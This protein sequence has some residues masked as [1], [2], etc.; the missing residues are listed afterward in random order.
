MKASLLTAFGPPEVLQLREDD[1]PVVKANDVL[2]RVHATT[3]N[4][5][6][7]LVRDFAAVSPST[8]HMPWLFWCLS[9]LAFGFGTPRIR[10]LELEDAAAAHRYAM[11]PDRRG[12]VVL[13][14]TAPER[15][16]P[17]ARLSDPAV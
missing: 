3:V 14:A 13:S 1:T 11:G 17:N 9:K 15:R 5:A 4:F 2:V 16:A 12:A 10:I 7:L 8:F 6:D